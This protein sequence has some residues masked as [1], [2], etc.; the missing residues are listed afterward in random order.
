ML[1][2]TTSTVSLGVLDFQRST[3]VVIILVL[4]GA[5][6]IYGGLALSLASR[7]DQIHFKLYAT[8]DDRPGGKHHLDLKHLQPAAAELRSAARWA[9]SHDSSDGFAIMLRGVLQD[10]GLDDEGVA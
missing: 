8:A 5:G 3:E 1:A 10:F 4:G 2:Q 7:F 6:R 9:R